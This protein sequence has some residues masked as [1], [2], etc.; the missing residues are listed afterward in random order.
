MS[1]DS[2]E[3]KQIATGER[4]VTVAQFPQILHALV[5]NDYRVMYIDFVTEGGELVTSPAV[6]DLE[7]DFIATESGASH[8]NRVMGLFEPTVRQNGLLSCN[9]E[10]GTYGENEV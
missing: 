3:L 7:L 4:L 8:F 9:V 2:V 5:E 1:L 6:V 10:I